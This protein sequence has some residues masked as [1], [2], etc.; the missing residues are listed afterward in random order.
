MAVELRRRGFLFGLAGALAFPA[1]VKAES[2]M[3]IASLNQFTDRDDL[4]L[5]QRHWVIDKY[6]NLIV[7]VSEKVLLEDRTGAYLPYFGTT[8]PVAILK[9]MRV[10]PWAAGPRYLNTVRSTGKLIL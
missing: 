8:D 4:L 5:T 1:I 3:R 7:K 9:G 10:A 2:I 6:K